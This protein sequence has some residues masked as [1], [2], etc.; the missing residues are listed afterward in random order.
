MEV[1]I[2]NVS[3]KA[4]CYASTNPSAW[5]R[6]T[7]DLSSYTGKTITMAFHF[8]AASVVN[9]AGWYIDDLVIN[10]S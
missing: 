8:L 9:Y 4:F 1:R 10:G 6:Y 3:V 7:I 2:N 5:V